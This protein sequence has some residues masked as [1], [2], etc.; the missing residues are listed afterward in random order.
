MKQA[1]PSES[2]AREV[3]EANLLRE[4]ELLIEIFT[5]YYD[6]LGEEAASRVMR[7]NKKL[8]EHLI[9][10]RKIMEADIAE[11]LADARE[12]QSIVERELTEF[13]NAMGTNAVEEKAAFRAVIALVK[14]AD[15]N[16]IAHLKQFSKVISSLTNHM[17]YYSEKVNPKFKQARALK[18][19]LDEMF[20]EAMDDMG[21]TGMETPP[22][23]KSLLGKKRTVDETQEDAEGPLQMDAPPA[24]ATGSAKKPRGGFAHF[25]NTF[26]GAQEEEAVLHEEVD[27]HPDL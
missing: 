20:V 18:N 15:T 9:P 19:V 14:K 27:D 16:S 8:K 23:G 1:K 2:T 11:R 22:A 24:P 12:S 21:G 17:A 5:S 4:R 13:K 25:L 3:R 10:L 26:L 6:N 7:N